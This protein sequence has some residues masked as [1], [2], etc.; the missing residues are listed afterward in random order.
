MKRIITINRT[1]GSDGREIGKA[2]AVKL[3]IHYYDKQLLKII[4]DRKDIPYEE[5]VK[6]DEKRASMWLYP[7]N[8]EYQMEPKYRFEPMNDILF[9]ETDKLIQ[10]LAEKEDCIIIGRCAN[11]ILKDRET[12]RSV[13]IHAPLENRLNT[14]MRRER[15]DMKEAKALIRK[16]DKQRRYYY[17]YY[18]DQ[19]W[20]D[21]EQ[22]HLCLDSS[23][24]KREEI[25]DILAAMYKSI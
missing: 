20:M 8:D 16:M 21:M 14:V 24:L 15:C 19:D 25:V 11:S 7:V 5:L 4:S 1:F 22:Y 9:G 12:V 23:K 6:V 3:G 13:F 18:T 17:N 10:E 2:L